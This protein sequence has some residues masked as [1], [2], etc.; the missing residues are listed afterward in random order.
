MNGIERTAMI[1]LLAAKSPLTL[2]D[3]CERVREIL[4]LPEFHFDS[5]NETEWGHVEVD[6]IEYN[7]SRPYEEG[8]LQEW[9]DTVPAGC[10]FGIS[11]I[12]YREHSH[13]NDHEWAVGHL[14]APVAQQLADAF[15]IPVR[16]HRTWC[17]PG[18]NVPR[19][20]DFHPK[21]A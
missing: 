5:E 12:L 13:A 6:N 19:T 17:G 15:N 3:F 2:R 14:V 18:N 8:T 10:N 11:L 1:E 21:A 20:Q 7:V 9:D 16:Y 4:D